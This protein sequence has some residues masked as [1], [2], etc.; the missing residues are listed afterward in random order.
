MIE[1]GT[2]TTLHTG[3]SYA[4]LATGLVTVVQMLRGVPAPGWTM[5]FL[6]TAVLTSATGFLFPFNGVLP[7]HVVGGIAL[8]VLALALAARYA[9]RLNG[10]WGPVYAGG[11]VASLYFL[12]FVGIAQAFAKVPVLHSAAPTQSEAP[13]AIAQAVALVGFIVL[14]IA[15][16]RVARR[17]PAAA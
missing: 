5:L 1:L 16:V 6:A 13:F 15:A 4:A 11:L 10:A 14:G 8:L 17:V 3:I 12:V 9:F 2:L 7:S